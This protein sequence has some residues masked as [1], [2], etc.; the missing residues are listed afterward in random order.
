MTIANQIKILATKNKQNEAQYELDR[1][2]TKISAL[3]SGNLNKYECLAGGD[4]NYKPSTAEQVRFEYS[5][6]G[7]VLNKVLDEINK[8]QDFSRD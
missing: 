1:K 4:L 2:E 8:R 5:P 7:K 3:S 6:F